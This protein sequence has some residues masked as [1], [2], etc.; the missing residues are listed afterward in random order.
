MGVDGAA[1]DL[2]GVGT[3]LAAGMGPRA[4]VVTGR[5]VDHL[6]DRDRLPIGELVLERVQLP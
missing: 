1:Q 4:D 3:V 2:L 5:I 6:V